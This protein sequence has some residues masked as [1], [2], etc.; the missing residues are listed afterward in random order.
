MR[1]GSKGAEVRSWQAFLLIQGCAPGP[2]DGVFGE[3]TER[4]TQGFQLAHSLDPDGVV[5]PATYRAAAELGWRVTT[6]EYR[7]LPARWFT[8]AERGVG[9]ISLIVIH[10]TEGPESPRRSEATAAWFASDKS[11]GSAHFIVDPS[12]VVQSVLERDIAWH[13][14]HKATNARSIG[15]EHCG[16]ADQSAA[17]WADANSDAEL[18]RSA[19]LSAALVKRYVI[20][21]VWLTPAE[22][23]AGASGFCGHVDVTRAF[24]VKAG[25]VDPGPR[26]PRDAYLA[27]VR[28]AMDQ[29][30]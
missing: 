10:T 24:G 25:H 11:A 12:Q 30:A 26:F 4:A 14:G 19:V 9:D 3:R 21:P 18:R 1:V 13:S 22:V 7:F 27:M 8:P 28:G 16:R 6:T 15:I 17:D 29:G 23:A 2:A 5:G 20:P